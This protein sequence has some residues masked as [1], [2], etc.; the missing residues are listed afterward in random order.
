MALDGLKLVAANITSSSQESLWDKVLIGILPYKLYYPSWSSKSRSQNGWWRALWKFGLE[1]TK[2]T[3]H[4][5]IQDSWYPMDP[6]R[7]IEDLN[8]DNFDHD[9]DEDGIDVK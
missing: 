8:G 4:Y 3:I 5:P 2:Y 6:S 1:F 7:E 9:E